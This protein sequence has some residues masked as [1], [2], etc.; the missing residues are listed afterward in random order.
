MC[1]IAGAWGAGHS[2]SVTAMTAALAHRGPDGSGGYARGPVTLGARRLSIVDV[3]GGAQPA[4]SETGEICVVA[5]GEI[6]NHAELRGRLKARGHRFRSRC[7]TEVIVHLYEE[8]GERCV[9]YL[10]G[11]F[12]F[13]VA[14]GDRLFL[15]RDRLGIKPLYY[16]AVPGGM[17]FASEI[18]ALLRS[19][20]LV[21]ALNMQALA[22]SR[23]IGFPVGDATFID[24]IAALRP[25]HTMTVT[26][27]PGGPVITDRP[28]YRL[29]ADRDESMTF[30][31]AQ[32]RL[33][34]ALR[35]AVRSHL[36]A[37]VEVGLILSGG[38]DSAVLAMLARDEGRP[39]RTFSV[40]CEPDHPD[41]AQA[42]RLAGDLGW[43]NH[44][45]VLTFEDFIG[46]IPGYV[47]AQESPARLGGLG[48]HV[49][50]QQAGPQL[51]ACLNGEGADELFG[52]YAEYADRSV[53]ARDFESRLRGLGAL[54]GLGVGLSP[55]AME[56]MSIVL[57]QPDAAYTDRLLTENLRDQL[58]RS[59]LTM[60]DACGMAASLE[61]R[62]P[63]LDDGVVELAMSMP[64][65]F[66]VSSALGIHKHVLRRAALRAWGGD[67]PLA[68]SILR[69]KIG[70]PSAGRQH[71]AQLADLCERE[72]PGDYLARHEHGGFFTAKVDLLL[73]ELFCEIFLAGRGA[74]PG[75]LSVREFIA[76]RAA[77]ARP[78]LI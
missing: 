59:H 7:D 63:Y 45:T 75:D 2:G 41:L 44:A 32:D 53:L 43:S 54:R 13:A 8:Y 72:L 77:R 57:A 65:R 15:A 10:S 24:G 35:A 12:A 51:K 42:A 9:E 28:Y 37:D 22:D 60:Q 71:R 74:A 58:V 39:V 52:G 19:P 70:A 55:R 17:L 16:A 73:H 21:P 78:A 5:N 27:G 49:L 56:L 25:G 50:Y 26:A 38:L 47:H 61:I 48:L 30:D 62:V 11:M 29:P 14:D 64:A 23:V 3:G 46:A 34:E 20:E 66:K 31:E 33:I 76:A 18:K 69:R 67:G 68:D 4:F 36:A 6:Y 40:G 1:G